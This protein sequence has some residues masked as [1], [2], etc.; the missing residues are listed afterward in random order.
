MEKL[1]RGLEVTSDY[2]YGI[3]QRFDGVPTQTAVGQ[4]ALDRYLETRTVPK[5]EA[6]TLRGIAERHTNPP[7]WADEWERHHTSVNLAQT[8]PPSRQSPRTPSRPV[9]RLVNR[10]RQ[11]S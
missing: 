9:V 4:M 11:P 6:E 2:L 10:E 3:G 1:A 7:V 8:Q 5:G